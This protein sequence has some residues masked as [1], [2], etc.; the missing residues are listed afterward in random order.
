[1]QPLDS[2]ESMVWGIFTLLSF[3]F[4]VW[5]QALATNG[6]KTPFPICEK[7]S[8]AAASALPVVPPPYF[9]RESFLRLVDNIASRN[10]LTALEKTSL[11]WI[12]EK[13]QTHYHEFTPKERNDIE[14][15]LMYHGVRTAAKGAVQYS[16]RIPN[17]DPAIQFLENTIPLVS[18][19]QRQ[20]DADGHLPSLAA[21]VK[22]GKVKTQGDLANDQTNWIDHGQSHAFDVSLRGLEVIHDLSNLGY[23]KNFNPLEK[24]ALKRAVVMVNGTHDMG[25][26]GAGTKGEREDHWRVVGKLAF[27]GE[28]PELKIHNLLFQKAI[29][30]LAKDK[31]NPLVQLITEMVRDPLLGKKYKGTEAEKIETVIREFYLGGYSHGQG[32]RKDGKTPFD[33]PLGVETIG[34]RRELYLE[35]LEIPLSNESLHE[36]GPNVGL[37]YEGGTADF[38][39]WAD[40]AVT[41]SLPPDHPVFRLQKIFSEAEG[42]LNYSDAN[43]SRGEGAAYAGGG[44]QIV[45]YVEVDPAQ[46]LFTP[47]RDGR[48]PEG[49]PILGAVVKADPNTGQKVIIKTGSRISSGLNVTMGKFT[50]APPHSNET[51]PLFE[52]GV[53]HTQFATPEATQMAATQSGRVIG[54]SYAYGLRGL[55]GQFGKDANQFPKLHITY[56]AKEETSQFQPVFEKALISSIEKILTR[57]KQLPDEIAKLDEKVRQQWIQD[58]LLVFSSK[59]STLKPNTV[60]VERAKGIERGTLGRALEPK[61]TVDFANRLVR[62]GAYGH[63]I[64]PEKMADKTAVNVVGTDGKPSAYHPTMLLEGARIIDL[65]NREKL[66]NDG[67]QRE[68]VYLLLKGSVTALP[69]TGGGRQAITTKA[70]PAGDIIPVFGATAFLT[71]RDP[72]RNATVEVSS[73]EGATVIAIPKKTAEKYWNSIYLA[74][75]NEPGALQKQIDAMYPEGP[76]HSDLGPAPAF[77]NLNNIPTLRP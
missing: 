75:P 65:K 23:F 14:G 20:F 5:N 51:R 27:G 74:I 8:R 30:D 26:F 58:N 60:E 49:N 11:G 56:P 64:P 42:I 32:K 24:E 55:A 25:M 53:R 45:R 9:N 43:R 4:T 38:M 63:G 57:N 35:Q 33:A 72:G 29:K 6:T 40:P 12:I 41:K 77:P 61:E 67:E 2:G 10:S 22:S 18:H 13:Y 7:T 69:K 46:I 28:I 37:Y 3:N 62:T 48:P 73:A 15:L 70:D 68:M 34:T 59:I 44:G 17:S 71:N 52:V 21:K 31:N 1:M 47:G 66:V 36:K 76:T 16:D 50:P 39:P 19:S 54:E